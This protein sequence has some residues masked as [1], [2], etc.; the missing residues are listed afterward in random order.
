MGGSLY[1]FLPFFWRFGFDAGR[2]RILG[3]YVGIF[4]KK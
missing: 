2:I 1:G 4:R 3:L